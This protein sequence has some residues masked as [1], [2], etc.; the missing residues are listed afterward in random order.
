MEDQGGTRVHVRITTDG[1]G[2]M[3]VY[4]YD[5]PVGDQIPTLHAFSWRTCLGWR[6][7]SCSEDPVSVI[8]K[9]ELDYAGAS[10]G[11]NVG[12]GPGRWIMARLED[13]L[14]KSMSSWRSRAMIKLSCLGSKKFLVDVPSRD[15]K[16][17]DVPGHASKSPSPSPEPLTTSPATLR[18]I[19]RLA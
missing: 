12:R 19:A 8:A 13:P 11:R 6:F 15:S 5:R 17:P 2:N 7:G 14:G 9:L 18:L 4:S 1:A 3:R 16:P 10:R